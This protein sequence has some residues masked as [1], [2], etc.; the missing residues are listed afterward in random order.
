MRVLEEEGFV[1]STGSA[2]SSR[3]KDRFRVLEN[4]GISRRMAASALRVST[5][6]GVGASELKALAAALRRRIPQL[7]K[8]TPG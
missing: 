8:V 6:P 7:L 5:G 1:V 2:C 4:M 3:K